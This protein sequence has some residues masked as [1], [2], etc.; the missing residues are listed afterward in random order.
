M[1]VRVAG[2]RIGGAAWMATAPL[3]RGAGVFSR[4]ESLRQ[5]RRPEIFTAR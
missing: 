2:L 3:G 5:T 1:I 4:T